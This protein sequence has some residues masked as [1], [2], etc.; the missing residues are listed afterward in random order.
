M[1][2]GIVIFATEEA[3]ER[4][5]NNQNLNLTKPKRKSSCPQCEID[6]MR[7]NIE[8]NKNTNFNKE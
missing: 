1:D 2:R 4:A 8:N 7:K 5:K 6:L 3:K